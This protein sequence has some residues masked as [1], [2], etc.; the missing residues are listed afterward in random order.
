MCIRD[1]VKDVAIVGTVVVRVI[2]LV[3]REVSTV[4]YVL[5]MLLEIVRV[6]EYVVKYGMVVLNTRV[7]WDVSVTVVND[8]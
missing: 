4:R 1:R 5:V 2:K 3:D 8:V 6:V 7:V